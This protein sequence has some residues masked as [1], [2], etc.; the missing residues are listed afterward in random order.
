MTTAPLARD[1]SATARLGVVLA[2]V[3]AVGYGTMIT[4]TRL[5][6]DDGS[7]PLTLI[8]ARAAVPAAILALLM[9]GRGS[10]FALLPGALWPVAG[11]AL[12]QL[13]ITIGYLSAVAY[14]P[15]SLAALVFY[16]YPVLVAGLLPLIGRGRVGWTAALAFL[17]AFAG[18]ALA[19]APSFAVLDPL[20]LALAVGAA[21]SGAALMLAAD[22]LPP[23]QD[24]LAVGLYMN[25]AAL[26]VAAPYAL[27]TGGLAAP[28]TAVGWG[29]IAYVCLGFLGAFLAMIG[30]VRYAGALRTAL[31]FNVEPVVA[32]A[33]A[34]LL[35]GE[36]L[37]SAQVLGVG[38]VFAALTLATLAERPSPPLPPPGA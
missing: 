1:F 36:T 4:A 34:V 26:A 18:L 5:S 10:A 23:A 14:I 7:N 8:C 11:I 9:L 24:M 16:A 12:G 29:A 17:A 6:Y 20:G 2:I 28:V 35:L 22:R 13:G 38:L 25:L 31:V 3:S 30:A 37:S 19:L 33:S 32:I 27:I 21:L 15:V